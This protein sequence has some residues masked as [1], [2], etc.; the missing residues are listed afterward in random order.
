ATVRVAVD[1]FD[2]GRGSRSK[3]REHAVP[4]IRWT[5]AQA[6]NVLVLRLNR[7]LAG[8]VAGLRRSAGVDLLDAGVEAGH[9]AESG[10]LGDL[11]HGQMRFVDQLLGEMQAASLSHCAGSCSQVAKEQTPQMART[12]SQALSEQFN[13]AIFEAS[14]ADQAQ[15]TR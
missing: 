1:G 10:S 2:P 11:E 4:V 12:D 6:K 5:E 9:A 14:F 3:I 8:E 13:A 15:R 7:A